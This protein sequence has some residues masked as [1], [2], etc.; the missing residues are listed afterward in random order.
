[1][2]GAMIEGCSS[3]PSLESG[4]FRVWSGLETGVHVQW[5]SSEDFQAQVCGSEP[6]P[7][8]C[9]AHRPREAGPEGAGSVQGSEAAE[10]QRGHPGRGRAL[11]DSGL[12]INGVKYMGPTGNPE[13]PS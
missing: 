10:R 4:L 11:W 5:T 6:P 13:K 3:G 7:G 2:G 9:A 1:M 12:V 8:A